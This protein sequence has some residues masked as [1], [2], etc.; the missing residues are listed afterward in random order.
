MDAISGMLRILR[1]PDINV[2]AKR[3]MNTSRMK[4]NIVTDERKKLIF[5]IFNLQLDLIGNGS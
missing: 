3:F 4:C 1:I 5:K 2:V